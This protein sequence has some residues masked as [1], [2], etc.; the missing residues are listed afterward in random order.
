MSHII[1]W[2]QRFVSS[3]GAPS[4]FFKSPICSHELLSQLPR[5][6][7]F[8]A[9]APVL[10]VHSCPRKDAGASCRQAEEVK[11]ALEFMCPYLIIAGMI[12]KANFLILWRKKSQGIKTAQS[13]PVQCD[14]DPLMTVPLLPQWVRMYLADSQS[15]RM[16][17]NM[18]PSAVSKFHPWFHAKTMLCLG[19]SQ[20]SK[21]RR[22]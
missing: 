12:W 5:Y 11:A 8:H 9:S 4:R 17:L 7:S 1:S 21:C 15:Q 10:P 14:I 18:A 6:L 19:C 2:G 13:S 3:P 22:H 16:W 20:A